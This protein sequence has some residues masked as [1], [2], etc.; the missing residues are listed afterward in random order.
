MV[1]AWPD[2]FEKNNKEIRISDGVLGK[3]YRDISNEVPMNNLL[4]FDY[5]KSIQLD[6]ELDS[7]ILGQTKNR[8]FMHSYLL[9]VYN[10]IVL[11]MTMRLRQ[12]MLEMNFGCEAEIF[13]SDLRFK[14]FDD[15]SYNC[16][17]SP[18]P[19]KNEDAMT[20]LKTRLNNLIE[21]YQQK[22][23]DLH[24]EIQS[25]QAIADSSGTGSGV[26]SDLE[27][28]LAIAIYL[29]SYAEHNMS[30][31]LYYDSNRDSHI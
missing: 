5:K 29:A 28:H 25:Q 7:R 23:S 11:P 16:Y 31:K 22:L 6:Y 10:E 30:T 26:D 1:T 3:M 17:K 2:Y 18:I 20:F 13:A 27:M 4:N 19:L 12:I 15:S 9:L 8:E 21:R 24:N 14:M